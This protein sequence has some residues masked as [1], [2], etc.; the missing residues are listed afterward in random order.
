ML[1][2]HRTG[3]HLG[4]DAADERVSAS[5]CIPSARCAPGA[6][7]LPLAW[8]RP[9]PLVHCHVQA[10]GRRDDERA[11]TDATVTDAANV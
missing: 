2:T 11:A 4:T 6:R 9:F 7:P 1:V 5:Y 8:I 3:A 10:D